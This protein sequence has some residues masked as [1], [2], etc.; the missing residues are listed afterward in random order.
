L[1]PLFSFSTPLFAGADTLAQADKVGSVN[2][3]LTCHEDQHAAG[4]MTAE[5]VLNDRRTP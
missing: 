1:D 4:S 3:C 2:R 5:F